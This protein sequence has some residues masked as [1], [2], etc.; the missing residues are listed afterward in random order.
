MWIDRS[1]WMLGYPWAD[2]T[3]DG[4]L[5]IHL[6]VLCTIHNI[7]FKLVPLSRHIEKCNQ[8][9]QTDDTTRNGAKKRAAMGGRSQTISPPASNRL[10]VCTSI[11][12]MARKIET[13]PCFPRPLPQPPT[14]SLNPVIMFPTMVWRNYPCLTPLL[15]TLLQFACWANPTGDINVLSWSIQHMSQL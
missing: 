15:F 10:C 2:L 6:W 14:H 8:Q 3:L 9:T 12:I 13:L 11:W 4:A 7:Q 5:V 1:I